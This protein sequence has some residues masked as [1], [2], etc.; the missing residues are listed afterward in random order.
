MSSEAGSIGDS[1]VSVEEYDRRAEILYRNM[2]EVS[3]NCGK[4]IVCHNYI[5]KQDFRFSAVTS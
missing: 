4:Y 1:S 5:L 2:K 3:K